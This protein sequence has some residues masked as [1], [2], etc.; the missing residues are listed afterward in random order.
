[1]IK[2]SNQPTLGKGQ[3]EYM[4]ASGQDVPEHLLDIDKSWMVLHAMYQYQNTTEVYRM[5]PAYYPV[6][7]GTFQYTPPTH[8]SRHR[9]FSSFRCMPQ[10]LPIWSSLIWLS[11]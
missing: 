5:N 2:L 3:F 10:P 7:K 4:V 6:F 1:M 11:K 9:H 8:K